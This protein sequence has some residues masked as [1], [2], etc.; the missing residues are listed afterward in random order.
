MY[1]W[2]KVIRDCCLRMQETGMKHL[3]NPLTLPDTLAGL[4]ETV[5]MGK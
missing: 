5:A 3:A 1:L 4:Q 2:L